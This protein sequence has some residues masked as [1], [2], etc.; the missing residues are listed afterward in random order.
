MKRLAVFAGIL[1]VGVVISQAGSGEPAPAGPAAVGEAPAHQE[2]QV[3]LPGKAWAVSLDLPG[4]TRDSAETRPDGSGAMLTATNEKTGLTVAAYLEK[5]QTLRSLDEC[6]RHYWELMRNSPFR[7]DDIHEVKNSRM[8]AVHYV[9]PELKGK[10]I[11][12][13][14]INAYLYRDG[15]CIDIHLSKM[16]YDVHADEPLFTAVL[17]TVRFVETP[18]AR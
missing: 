18:A 11:R 2:F 8:Y 10:P 14:N 5:E 12:Q 9:I 7:K 3:S 1:A 17:E 13:K 6:K 15:C 16:Q 4:F